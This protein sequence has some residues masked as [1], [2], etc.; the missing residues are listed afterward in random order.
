MSDTPS[1]SAE[2]QAGQGLGFRQDR[3]DRVAGGESGRDLGDEAEQ[4]RLV[5]RDDP[6]PPVGSGSENDRNGAATGLT[7]PSTAW[8]LSVQPA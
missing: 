7:P 5:G 6:H 3:D 1:T 2:V 8:N 4:R